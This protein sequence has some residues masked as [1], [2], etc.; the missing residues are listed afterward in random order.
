MDNAAVHNGAVKEVLFIKI[1]SDQSI[2]QLKELREFYLESLQQGLCIIP[3]GASWE[4]E[5]LSTSPVVNQLAKERKAKG[6]VSLLKS[7]S[8][9]EKDAILEK[10][11]QYREKVGAP[12]FACLAQKYGKGDKEFREDILRDLFFYRIKVSDRV[13]IKLGEALEAEG[14]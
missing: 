9:K 13:W 4:L 11:Q 8:H 12:S 2:E 5:M 10:L 1:D 6:D 3:A 7:V 14:I